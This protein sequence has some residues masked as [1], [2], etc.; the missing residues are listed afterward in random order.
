M[1]RL[2]LVTGNIE[3]YWTMQA[4]VQEASDEPHLRIETI[5]GVEPLDDQ[6]GVEVLKTVPDALYEPLFGKQEPTDADIKAAGGDP[7]NVTP[8]HTYAILDAAKVMNL[9][10]MLKDSGLEHRCLFQGDAE[11]ELGEVAPWVV[12]LDTE[13]S[14]V[15]KLF[16]KSTSISDIWDVNH[17]IFIRSKGS[18]KQI[19][20]HFRKF[21][22]IQTSDGK[23]YYF[24]FW[25]PVSQFGF[26]RACQ[27]NQPEVRR[28]FECPQMLLHFEV[29][30]PSESVMV[31]PIVLADPTTS[32]LNRVSPSKLT[33]QIMPLIH[34]RRVNL[35]LLK[36]AQK[37]DPDQA[38]TKSPVFRSLCV[39]FEYGFHKD[40]QL[41]ALCRI[42]KAFGYAFLN[43]P[44]V[45]SLLETSLV[46]YNVFISL[47]KI[48]ANQGYQHG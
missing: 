14:F 12:T 27:L 23:W 15:R 29:Y 9:P 25:E 35:D 28:F 31:R 46:D 3:D 4:G 19:H 36:L 1:R 18:L 37:I 42:D 34:S 11:D 10:E 20:Q 17:G 8:V 43:Q 21:T 13:N 6:F 32:F 45:R 5:D 38:D 22:K 40:A 24:R 26:V 48:A 7:A 16:S 44:N 39:L 33:E 41:V 47:T 2:V 30:F